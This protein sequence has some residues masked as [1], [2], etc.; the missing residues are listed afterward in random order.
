MAVGGSRAKWDMNG[1]VA[2]GRWSDQSWPSGPTI[3]VDG[4]IIEPVSRCL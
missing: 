3:G 1:N 4:G 2:P